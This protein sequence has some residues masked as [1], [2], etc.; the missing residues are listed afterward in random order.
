MLLNILLLTCSTIWIRRWILLLNL[1]V[2]ISN[3][4]TYEQIITTILLNLFKPLNITKYRN[5]EMALL[6]GANAISIRVSLQFDRSQ[7]C[8][9]CKSSYVGC[10]ETPALSVRKKNSNIKYG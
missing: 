7:L 1:Y 4:C 6:L 8:R 2:D 10:N 9:Y 3:C 5:I